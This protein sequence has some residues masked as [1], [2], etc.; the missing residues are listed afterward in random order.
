MSVSRTETGACLSF[1][2]TLPEVRGV[3]GLRLRLLGLIM[4]ISSG[5]TW[6]TG[7]ANCGLSIRDGTGDPG[8]SVMSKHRKFHQEILKCDFPNCAKKKTWEPMSEN[9][10]IK[11]QVCHQKFNTKLANQLHQQPMA[12]YRISWQ[13][14]RA[15]GTHGKGLVNPDSPGPRARPAGPCAAPTAS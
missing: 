8:H 6:L 7:L 12:A 10:S 4:H 9:F 14:T 5:A 2:G 13:I 15:N 1:G 11:V 3:E